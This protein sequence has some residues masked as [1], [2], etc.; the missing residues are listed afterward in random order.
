MY[1]DGRVRVP[2]IYGTGF[3][4]ADVQHSGAYGI[5]TKAHH[6]SYLNVTKI[7]ILGEVW[8]INCEIFGKMYSLLL[9]ILIAVVQTRWPLAENAT[10]ILPCSVKMSKCLDSW[11]KCYRQTRLR[12]IFRIQ[13]VTFVSR[14]RESSLICQL[15]RSKWDHVLRVARWWLELFS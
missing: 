9:V 15:Q 14:R 4:G 12:N 10:I 13:S 7:Y 11:Q 3:L 8:G 6:R 1:S 2:H 5:V